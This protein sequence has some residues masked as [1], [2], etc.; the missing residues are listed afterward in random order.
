MSV[1]KT[2]GKKPKHSV[3]DAIH[4]YSLAQQDTYMD[5]VAPWP[6]HKSSFA[7]DPKLELR[8]RLQAVIG[9]PGDIEITVVAPVGVLGPIDH[10]G[11]EFKELVQRWLLMEG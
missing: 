7:P 1:T 11:I 4:L 2:Y 3:L 10:N 6:S 9:G 8:Y 5:C